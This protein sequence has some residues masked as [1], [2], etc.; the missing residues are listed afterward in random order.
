MQR[1]KT[2][3]R[4]SRPAASSGTVWRRRVRS[5]ARRPAS[6]L[7]RAAARRRDVTTSGVCSSTRRQRRCNGVRAAGILA[8]CAACTTACEHGGHRQRALHRDGL[9]SKIRRVRFRRP[10]PMRLVR[11]Q[12]R[13]GERHQCVRRSKTI[14]VRPSQRHPAALCGDGV[15][16]ARR[17]DKQGDGRAAARQRDVTTS[18]LCGRT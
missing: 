10:R 9:W 14:N 5:K 16:A 6:R 18:G 13:P 4:A 12:A 3:E 7:G 2:N 17:G 11:G 15:C 1:S 8:S